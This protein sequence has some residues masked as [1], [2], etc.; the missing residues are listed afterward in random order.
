MIIHNMRYWALADP[1]EVSVNE[2]YNE[3]ITFIVKNKKGED[4]EMAVVEEFEVDR[5]NYCAAALVE[6]E[7]INEDELYIYRITADGDDFKAEMIT[8]AREYDL[9]VKAYTEMEMKDRY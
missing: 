3:Y 5:K 1:V 7:Y 8:D 4:M 9:V 6:G 2:D